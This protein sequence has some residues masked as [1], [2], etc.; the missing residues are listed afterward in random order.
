MPT[1]VTFGRVRARFLEEPVEDRRAGRVVTSQPRLEIRQEDAARAKSGFT[2]LRL[3]GSRQKHGHCEEHQRQRDLPRHQT[4]ATPQ[5]RR[6]SLQSR[7]GPECLRQIARAGG[8]PGRH[9]TREQRADR[10]HRQ[11]D[12]DRSA[13]QIERQSYA[14]ITDNR[15]QAEEANAAVC[16]ARPRTPPAAAS[17][18]LSVIS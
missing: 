4:V 17:R 18:K 6:S 8:A 2:Q 3:E 5:A 13:V 1:V 16:D 14:D 9:K 15:Q 10:R 11:A 12:T 7:A